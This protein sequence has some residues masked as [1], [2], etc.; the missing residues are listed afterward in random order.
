MSLP[1]LPGNV[2]LLWAVVYML[3]GMY[4]IPLLLSFFMRKKSADK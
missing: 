3:V 2:S 4:G 1:N